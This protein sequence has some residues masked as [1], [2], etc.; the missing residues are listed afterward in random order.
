MDEIPPPTPSKDTPLLQLQQQQP[1]QRN[2]L[3]S[4]KTKPK[5]KPQ[6]LKPP[7]LEHIPKLLPVFAEIMRPLLLL[8]KGPSS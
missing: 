1:S 3:S 4:V 8:R 5:K 2:K 6:A 7:E